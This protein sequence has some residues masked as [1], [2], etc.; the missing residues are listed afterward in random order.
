MHHGERKERELAPHNSRKTSFLQLV[1][2]GSM[3]KNVNHKNVADR[4]RN[5]F[6]YQRSDVL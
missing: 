3:G 1:F 5:D 2:Y 6:S 4:Q